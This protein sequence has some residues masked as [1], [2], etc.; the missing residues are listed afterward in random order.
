MG[1]YSDQLNPPDVPLTS[2]PH[3]F[4]RSPDGAAL[5][6]P[7]PRTASLEFLHLEKV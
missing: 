7:A 2:P 4:I 6:L 5:T 3:G 1:A